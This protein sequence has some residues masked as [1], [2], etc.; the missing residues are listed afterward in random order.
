VREGVYSFGAAVL[1]ASDDAVAAVAVCINKAQLGS[2]RGARH[3]DAAI[4]VARRLTERL[5]GEAAG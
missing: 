1:D 5:G 2:E 3:R 4:D